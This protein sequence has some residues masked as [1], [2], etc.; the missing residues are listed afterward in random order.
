MEQRC[1]WLQTISSIDPLEWDALLPTGT[2]PCHEWGWLH[3]MEVSGSI[4][5]ATG[6]EPC[7]LVV[8]SDEGDL[9]AA[10]VLYVKHN[11]NGEYVYDYYWADIARRIGTEYYP[12][13]VATI[14]ATPSPDYRFL[15]APKQDE[16][17]LT[18]FMLDQIDQF[19]KKNGM[20]SVHFLFAEPTLARHLEARKM[21]TWHHHRYLWTN[22]DYA[23]F[24]AFLSDFGKNQRRNIRRERESVKSQNLV[25]DMRYASEFSALE[26][27]NH[28]QWMW[29][30]YRVTNE[31]FGPWA[32]KYLNRDFFFQAVEH[33][34]HSLLFARA[35]LPQSNEPV[36]MALLLRR[37]Q[38]LYGRFWGANGF[39]PDLHFE[40]CYYLPIEW[41]IQEGIHSFDPG[42]GSPH[43]I[44]RGFLTSVTNSYH[45]YFDNRLQSIF[46]GLM[47]EVNQFELNQIEELNKGSPLVHNHS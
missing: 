10:A 14:A 36:A 32:A 47:P 21:G 8:R 17:K 22:H 26:R 27:Q 35:R 29:D 4:S 38:Q 42:A 1:E 44:R 9:Q 46:M 40:L 24:S 30:F 23:D 39:Y 12:K 7:H 3:S 43:K 6:W 41:C 13:L 15:F 16:T 28:A 19:A 5:P 37:D 25:L 45:Q 18:E 31:Q 2:S 34:K 33:Y 11:S 20:H